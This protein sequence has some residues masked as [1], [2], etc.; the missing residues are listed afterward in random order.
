MATVDLKKTR[1][2]EL[3]QVFLGWLEFVWVFVFRP[4][5][6]WSAVFT[7][8]VIT[9]YLFRGRNKM[10][11]YGRENLLFARSGTLVAS[12]HQSM[13]D[14]FMKGTV[15][16]KRAWFQQYIYPWNFAAAENFMSYW[17]MRLLLSMFRTY[18]VKS[19]DTGK[20]ADRSALKFAIE[21]LKSAHIDF[22]P[23]G[24][25]QKDG[26]S[27]RAPRGFGMIAM[28]AENISPWAFTGMDQ[29]LP[30][31]KKAT[32]IPPRWYSGLGRT[33][34]VLQ[35]LEWIAGIR[36]GKTIRVKIGPK[37]TA[38]ELHQAVA[39]SEDPAQAAADLVMGRI[40]ALYQELKAME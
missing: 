37:I 15:Y 17:W 14:S 29:A 35:Y 12:N 1:P 23:A 33:G 20:R 6:E 39:D 38:E 28:H 10:L 7:S 27:Y 32:D 24:T 31:Y 8:G 9:Y 34:K 16:G 2:T 19:S 40:D 21:K 36:A 11:I 30:Y 13:I 4:V 5:V 22:F 25:R 18:G 26:Q 3:S